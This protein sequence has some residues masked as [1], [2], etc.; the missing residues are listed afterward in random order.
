MTK[1]Y[2]NE[3]IAGVAFAGALA[4]AVLLTAT[5]GGDGLLDGS[6]D[7][8]AR[9]T[10]QLS[11]ETEARIDALESRIEEL[12]SEKT[13]AASAGE[14]TEAAAARLAALEGK[15]AELAAAAAPAVEVRGPELGERR[16]PL[17]LRVTAPGHPAA[18]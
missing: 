11:D 7:V 9:V 5:R 6:P 14:L 3:T 13:D 8:E 1:K 17:E 2:S 15:M 10:A 4:L 18:R 16:S 12:I